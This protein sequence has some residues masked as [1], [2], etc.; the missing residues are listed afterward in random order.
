MASNEKVKKLISLSHTI[1]EAD[2][3]IE[4]HIGFDDVKSKI[5]FLT[6]MFDHRVVFRKNDE[7]TDEL[8]E[9]YFALLTTIIDIEE[10][11][12]EL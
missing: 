10:E 11:P 8:Q 3:V 2:A 1:E 4:E 5:S 9:D 6:G 7:T 12:F